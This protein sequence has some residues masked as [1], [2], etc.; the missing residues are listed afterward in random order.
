MP[1]VKYNFRNKKFFWIAIAVI[2]SIQL[3]YA[4]FSKEL[5]PLQTRKYTSGFVYDYAKPFFYFYY[6]KG[7][8]PVASL[9]KADQYSKEEADRII[10]ENGESLIM[11][12]KHWTRMGENARIWALMPDAWIKGTAQSPSVKTFNGLIFLLSLLSVFIGFYQS[13]YPLLGLLIT[14]LFSLTPFYPYEIYHQKNIFGLL[15]SV[16]LIVLGLNSRLLFRKTRLWIALLLSILSGI[17]VAFFTE[18]RGEIVVVLI[19][20]IILYVFSPLKVNLKL[21]TLLFLFVSFFSTRMLIRQYFNNKFDQAYS[22]VK[23]H[24][25]HPY[26]G[27]RMKAHSFWHPVWCGLGDFDKKHGYAWDDT[28]AYRYALP[29]MKSQYGLSLDYSGGYGLDEYYDPGHLYYKKLEEF[30]EYDLVVKQKVL[31]DIKSDPLWYL[32]I[33]FRRIVRIFTHTLPFEF[34]GL[35]FFPVVFWL[36]RN[37]NYP[38]LIML[39]AS[40]PLS[41]TPLLIFSGGNSTFNS[42]FPLLTLAILLQA[43]I[44]FWLGKKI[45]EPL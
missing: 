44:P 15:A 13:G 8:F 22:L 36:W 40:L 30:P 33:L 10:R 6:Y 42:V 31:K 32:G 7:L 43:V 26:N 37:K 20:L 19:S 35:L 27:P 28:R 17:M 2:V 23:N 3:L 5:K 16:F 39:L 34:A 21:M 25:G 41:L 11:E 12:Y 38:F 24:H 4:G 14:L 18:I 45:K 9:E 29:V 1:R